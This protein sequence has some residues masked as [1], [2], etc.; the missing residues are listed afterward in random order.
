MYT[1]D[2]LTITFA[3]LEDILP[4]ANV[5]RAVW[6]STYPNEELGI[7]AADIL[8]KDFFSTKRTDWLKKK[9]TEESDGYHVWVVKNELE[10]V[11]GFCQAEKNLKNHKI[12]ALYVLSEYQGR[13]LGKKLMH[14]ALDWLGNEKEIVLDV[15]TYNQNAIRFYTSLGFHFTGDSTPAEELAKLPSGKTMPELR[16]IKLF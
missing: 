2:N 7:T 13:G 14:C 15:V 11:V 12:N 9:L 4:I 3:T 10:K 5:H 16:M 6:L 8:E 1:S